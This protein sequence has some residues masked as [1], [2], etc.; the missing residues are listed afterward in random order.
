MKK[1]VL[2]IEGMT[3]SACSSGLEKYLKKQ[4]GIID[5]SVNLVMSF[6]SISYEGIK[7]KEIEKY[8]KE[9]GFKS[10][11]EWKEIEEEKTIK[12]KKH[13][14]I[15]F[16]CFTILLMYISMG[17]MFSLPTIPFLNPEKDHLNY[18]FFL[19]FITCIYLGYGRDIL[20]NGIKTLVHWMPNMD[21]LVMLSVASSFLYS[22]Y[23]LIQI[24]QGRI[25]Y[26]D[27]LY[28]ES[29]CMV[30]FFIKFGRW[31]E[32]NSHK[33]TKKAI[34]NLVQITPK[35]AIRKEGI[36]EKEVSLDE[37]KKGDILICKPGSK[38]AVDGKVIKGQTHVDESFIT[39]ESMPVLKKKNAIVIAGAINYEGTIEYQAEKIG[40][41]STISEI[42]QLVIE[43]T[44]RKSKIQRIADTV[45]GYFVPVVMVLSI[46]SFLINLLLK[47]NFFQSLNAFVTTLVVAC[48]CALG[49]AVP[50]VVVISNGLCARHGLY[51]K[52]AEALELARS[53]DTIVFD[54]T[55]TLTYG[56][57]KIHK[58]FTYGNLKESELLKIVSTLESKSLH[59]IASA[60]EK[61]DDDS[62]EHFK[63]INGIGIQGKIKEKEYYIG[64]QKVLDKLNIKE[65]YEKDY[66]E[67]IQNG[68][69][70]LYVIEQK[71]IIG[72]IG[73]KDG[74]RQEMKEFIQKLEREQ[75]EVLMLTGDNKVT[76][77]IVAKELG[78]TKVIAD[79]LPKDKSKIIRDLV[80]QDKKVI[81]VG[82][83]VN[84]ALALT[85]ATIGIS[86]S[87]GTDIAQDSA[88]VIL[89]NENMNHILD[90]IKISKR[91]YHIIKQNLFWAFF[92]NIGMIPIAMG[93]IKPFGIV[94]TP[95]IGSLAMT[96]SSLTVV[97]NSLRLS[98]KER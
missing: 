1:I 22:C 97:F 7:T 62:V 63:N 71:Q 77:N 48:P 30:I 14:L 18:A 78:I 95:M 20:K 45:S 56:K 54:K 96:L 41:N 11:G 25:T 31:I 74:I 23:G 69:S 50:L 9:A 67:L 85:E 37:I 8:I 40:K 88:S 49:L 28:F 32:M 89:M 21:T 87:G 98:K 19:F 93:I 52:Q 90:F 2:Q 68:C 53:I 34:Q 66:R 36:E 64:N 39:G 4:P 17:H 60:F 33:K 27:H 57:L 72:L 92:Y 81:M 6:A 15:F 13:E 94:I 58:V 86:V 26:V 10:K 44:N 79:V 73:V 84:D 3:C 83:G 5:A 46:I 91:A 12:Q 75:I 16:G 35:T 61:V 70:I 76:A 65:K 38:I 51:L 29:S 80:K 59:P 42:V 43:A 82:D 47:N 55:G 24:T